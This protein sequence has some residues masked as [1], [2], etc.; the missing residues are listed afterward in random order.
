MNEFFPRITYLPV[1]L[2]RLR[3]LPSGPLME[4]AWLPYQPVGRNIHESSSIPGRHML[5]LPPSS[6]IRYR[7]YHLKSPPL[8]DFWSPKQGG[9][10]T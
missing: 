8:E 4:V 7:G 6:L 9:G 5:N 2:C 10:G 3:Y 1:N